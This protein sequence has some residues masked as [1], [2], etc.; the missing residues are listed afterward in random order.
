M[1]KKREGNF[2]SVWQIY[3]YIPMQCIN[4]SAIYLGETASIG[5]FMKNSRNYVE[6][7][8]MRNLYLGRVYGNRSIDKLTK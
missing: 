7:R 8:I 4:I 5:I 6:N 3:L 1:Y 2:F